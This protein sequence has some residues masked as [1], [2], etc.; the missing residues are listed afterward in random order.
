MP[1]RFDE[2]EADECC[3]CTA[4]K[5]KQRDGREVK[6]GDPLVVGRKKPRPQ[7]I[8]FGEV[9]ARMPHCGGSASPPSDF[10]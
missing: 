1:L 3:C 9:V 10:T 6:N 5:E 7:A 8:I 4:N 2:L